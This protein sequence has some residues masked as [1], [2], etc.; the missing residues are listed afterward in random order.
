MTVWTGKGVC[1]GVVIGRA[2][3]LS[4]A[5]E[6]VG[7][8]SVRDIDAELA[9]VET[10][11][12]AAASEISELYERA[13]R[14][15]GEESA[16]IFEIHG[17]MLEDSDFQEAIMDVIRTE[18]VNAEYAV[19]QASKRFSEMLSQMD[20]P[21]MQERATDVR[22]ISARLCRIL[23]GKSADASEIEAGTIL[24]ARDLTPSQTVQIDRQKIAAFVTSAGSTNSHT[25][26]LARTLGIPAVVGVGEDLMTIADGDE[27]A[28]DGE[29]GTI[30]VRPDADTKKTLVER[31]RQQDEQKERLQ[32]YRGLDNV[33]RDGKRIEIFA[34]VQ[35]ESELSEPLL[36]EAG[37]IG[38]FRS[39]FLYLNRE[40]YPSEEEQFS[41]YCRVLARMG[42]KKVIIRTLDVG[43]DKQAPYFGLDDEEN[44]ALGLRGIRVCLS[45]PDVFRT[46]LRALYRASHHGRL[47]IMFPMITSVAEVNEALCLCDRVRRELKNEGH[48]ISDEVEI[49]MMIETP[50]SALIADRLAPLVDFFSVGT[51][52]L[53]QYTLAIDRQ[54][55]SV[56]RFFDEHHESLLRLI[57]MAAESAHRCG[58]WIGVC[59]ELGADVTMIEEFLRMGIDEISVTPR[60]I[61]PLRERIRNLDLSKTTKGS[62]GR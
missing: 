25:A 46:Q 53:S 24:C 21:Y 17:M 6:A 3:V 55:R 29:S 34:N 15:A 23:K 22:D 2:R 27:V 45:R 4:G 26:I 50:A 10:A 37:G 11:L 40:D 48:T 39:E 18:R 61:L 9:R 56:A 41:A 7:R 12:R 47:G 14:E 20:D 16:A 8:Y 13:L 1:Q 60:A 42:N 57:R 19:M 28:V 58:K 38:L 33:T 35:S 31:M 44:P 43:A 5:D 49:G 32:R 62:E 51:N 52:D 59:G 54:N 30:Y 36:D